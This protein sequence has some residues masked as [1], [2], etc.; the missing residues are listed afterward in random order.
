MILLFALL[1]LKSNQNI[2]IVSC[3]SQICT[4]KYNSS[5]N[6]VVKKGEIL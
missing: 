4:T 3:Q 2:Y 5:I 6:N 1:P